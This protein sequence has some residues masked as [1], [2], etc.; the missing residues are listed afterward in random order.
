M[1]P[2]K[3][4][5]VRASFARQGLMAAIGAV[6]AELTPGACTLVLPFSDAV[7]QQHGFFHG[8]IVG[9]L[10]D[11]A[12]GYA[13]LSLAPLESEVVTLE[14]KVNF[15]RPAAGQRL[16]A[17]G[18]VLRAGRSVTVARADVFIER[19]GARVLCATILQS[20]MAPPAPPLDG[21]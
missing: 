10:A 20:I 5:E 18:T 4:R 15:L 16:V 1:T 7:G 21:R 14:Y 13:A 11:S 19:D 9:A 3:E 8:G 6:M 17:M 2:D 12:G